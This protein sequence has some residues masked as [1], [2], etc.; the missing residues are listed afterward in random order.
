M[1]LFILLVLIAFISSCKTKADKNSNPLLLVKSRIDTSLYRIDSSL[2]KDSMLFTF[3]I[4]KSESTNETLI[5]E[6]STKFIDTIILKQSMYNQ[7]YVIDDFNDDGYL[8]IEL[9]TRQFRPSNYFIF[10]P[11]SNLFIDN[12]K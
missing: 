6:L 11:S 7:Q 4:G 12:G 9:P 8:D 10:N 3:W 1:R 2:K 5:V